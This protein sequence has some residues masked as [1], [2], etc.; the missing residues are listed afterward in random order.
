[1]STIGRWRYRHTVL[2]LCV[3]A[4][5]DVRFIEFALSL[6]FPNIEAALGTSVF[7]IGDAVTASTVT[8]A[9]SQLPSGAL[10]DRF[11]ERVII[12]A[13]GLTGV[14]SLVLLVAPVGGAI[15][16]GMSIIGAVTGTYYSPATAL[17]SDLFEHTG[18]AIGIHRVGA[19]IVGL[20]GP[21]VTFLS[22]TYG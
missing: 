3:L 6:V 9:L 13:L 4:Y 10:G 7:T 15:V 22:V 8:Y 20:T 14:A 18:R 11:G 16:V 1:M 21:V 17:L 19:Q 12:A 2:L 5:F